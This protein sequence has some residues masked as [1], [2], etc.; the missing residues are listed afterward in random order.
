MIDLLATLK[1]SIQK[2]LRGHPTGYNYI[3]NLI[4]CFT[5]EQHGPLQDKEPSISPYPDIDITTSTNSIDALL[6][7]LNA[8]KAVGSDGI[9]AR[10]LKEMHT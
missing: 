7:N 8:H 5:E 1:H 9:I 10:V 2:E 4:I 6:S 3:N